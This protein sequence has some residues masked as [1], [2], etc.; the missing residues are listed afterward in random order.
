MGKMT[1]RAN[2]ELCQRLAVEFLG[3]PEADLLNTVRLE[4]TRLDAEARNTA[5]PRKG[6]ASRSRLFSS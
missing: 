1:T 5:H 3:K 4:F 2:I 6:V